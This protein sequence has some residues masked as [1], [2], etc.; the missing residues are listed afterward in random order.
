MKCTFYYCIFLIFFL[1]FIA[2]F[3]SSEILINEIMYNNESNS[4]GDWVEL[5]NPQEDTINITNW[6][7]KDLA[8]NIKNISS[9][10]LGKNFN[11]I[12]FS[13]RLNNSGDTIYLYNPNNSLIDEITYDNVD[14]GFSYSRCPDGGFSFVQS[15]P[16]PGFENNCSLSN[17]EN[18]TNETTSSIINIKEYPFE[19]YNNGTEF[20]VVVE[21]INFSNGYYDLKLLVQDINGK[22]I[23]EVYNPLLE[24][25]HSPNYYNEEVLINA[26]NFIYS[27]RIKINSDYVGKVFFSS[28]IRKTNITNS[29]Y[30]TPQFSLIVLN[31]TINQEE[32]NIS[33]ESFL[34]FLDYPKNP[35]FGDK[36]DISFHVYKGDT[37]KYAV[38]IYAI[39]DESNKVSEKIT[40]HAGNSSSLSKFKDYYFDINLELNCLNDSGYYYL[41]LE[42]LDQNE[43]Q[44]IEIEKCESFE[45]ISNQKEEYIIEPPESILLGEKI[46][47][48]IKIIN[49]ENLEKSFQVWSY[50]YRS[51]KCYSCILEREE[52]MQ[53]ILLE[54]NSENEIILD[55]QVNEA[56]SGEYNLKIKILK[57]GLKTPKEF[58]YSI[59]LEKPEENITL[60][61]L[62]SNLLSDEIK[63]KSPK[64]S[65]SEILSIKS[66][67]LNTLPYL[68]STFAML[69]CIYL[70]IKKM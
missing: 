51:S 70:I 45:E 67:L 57:E 1:S 30:E 43:N 29:L 61:L 28:K 13:N 35:N 47:S 50:I 52:N 46:I 20:E 37:N 25:W 34:E 44:K 17:Q 56:E 4:S 42:G 21:I 27:F 39:D 32:E 66:L 16:T 49:H 65:F 53:E 24:D 10:I 6:Y 22:N 63:E 14:A 7:I 12:Y 38:Y 58:T 31:G 40:V 15:F 8:G 36:L 19:V 59:Y 64:L 18:E 54:P 2:N 33:E 68:F 9:I 23:G 11:I 62:E 60:S 48:K 5:Y 69:F 26:P 41:I 3:V 55:N